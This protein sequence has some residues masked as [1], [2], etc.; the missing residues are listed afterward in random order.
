MEHNPWLQINTEGSA[1]HR[2][3]EH[4]YCL[5]CIQTSLASLLTLLTSKHITCLQTGSLPHLIK[6]YD[7]LVPIQWI[8]PW[9]CFSLQ[10]Q[11]KGV[12]HLVK[13][14]RSIGLFFWLLQSFTSPSSSLSSPSFSMSKTHG[15]KDWEILGQFYFSKANGWEKMA[16]KKTEW[17]YL[18]YFDFSTYS[19]SCNTFNTISSEV[20]PAD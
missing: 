1:K 13:L 3:Q 17:I 14:A 18:D 8:F 2:L 11:Q 19:G 5:C 4:C 15:S 7:F 20:L 16:G 9:L 10:I 6:L 12:T